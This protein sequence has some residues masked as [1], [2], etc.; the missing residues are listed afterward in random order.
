MRVAIQFFLI[1]LMIVFGS[2][3]AAQNALTYEDILQSA[4]KDI[5]TLNST[6]SKVYAAIMDARERKGTDPSST[7][8]YQKMTRGEQLSWRIAYLK[9]YKTALIGIYDMVSEETNKTDSINALLLRIEGAANELERRKAEAPA[10]ANDR[11]TRLLQSVDRICSLKDGAFRT[12]YLFFNPRGLWFQDTL[13]IFGKPYAVGEDVGTWRAWRK[14]TAALQASSGSGANEEL[15][16]VSYDNDFLREL[17]DVIDPV[18]QEEFTLI[19]ERERLDTEHERAATTTTEAEKVDLP[20]NAS[21]PARIQNAIDLLLSRRDA[22]LTDFVRSFEQIAQRARV[23]GDEVT[24][25][26]F[27][28][29]QGLDTRLSGESTGEITKAVN[30]AIATLRPYDGA[31]LR[32]L[33]RQLDEDIKAWQAELGALNASTSPDKSVLRPAILNMQIAGKAQRL[34]NLRAKIRRDEVLLDVS[35]TLA[36]GL[37]DDIVK[38]DQQIARLSDRQGSATLR[39]YG[40][41]ALKVLIILIAAWLL[42]RVASL[43]GRRIL[44][45]YS[46][47]AEGVTKDMEARAKTLTSVF[48]A[49]ARVVVWVTAFLMILSEFG[50]NYQPLLLATGGLTLAVGFGAQ[51]LV[52]DF[53]SGFFI[54]LENQ[55]Q[56]GDV[57]E[58]GGKTGSV[59]TVSLRTTRI[60]TVDGTLHILPNGEITSVSNLTSG[61]ARFVVTVS[62]G[63][64]EDPDEVQRLL[65]QTGKEMFADAAWSKR[66]LEAPATTGVE[67]FGASS[68]D[69]RV[70][71]K[72]VPGEQWAAA[73]EFRKRVKV[74]FDLNNIEIPYS[75]VNMIQAEA[76]P[77]KVVKKHGQAVRIPQASDSAVTPQTPTVPSGQSAKVDPASQP[78]RMP[79]S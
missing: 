7:D 56:V 76:G 30:E 53:F 3:L 29:K 20:P 75:Y 1:A 12:D 61:W 54:L 36:A 34:T 73:R 64:N 57:I 15:F 33:E 28:Q 48:M 66:L 45:H 50:I 17:Q 49:A 38:F 4:E 62:A 42:L 40:F 37:V 16:H 67:N 21:E 63:Y 13:D 68:V 24:V 31:K 52:K 5:A 10:D 26:A 74:A 77:S 23:I 8:A 65:D 51:S 22:S 60:R 25:T 2:S 18:E 19:I 46:V 59:E 79:G 14:L 71:A 6:A 35:N 72:T 55:F 27:L 78:D 9:E 58:I 41:G 39:F 44:S 43:M 47:G 11:T 70:M 32:I 69:F